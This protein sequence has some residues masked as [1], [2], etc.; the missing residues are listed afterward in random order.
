[1]YLMKLVTALA[2]APS[3]MSSSRR[4]ETFDD[5]RGMGGGRHWVA[6]FGSAPKA[7]HG[8]QP[9]LQGIGAV[10]RLGQQSPLLYVFHRIR[11]GISCDI[12]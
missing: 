10:G 5:W 11:I 6:N 4:E 9:Y 7:Q 2:A 1:V 8:C 3:V 12:G